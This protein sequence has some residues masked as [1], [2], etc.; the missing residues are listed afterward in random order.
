MA[1]TLDF[2]NNSEGGRIVQVGYNIPYDVYNAAH[3]DLEKTIQATEDALEEILSA[4]HRMRELAV[5]AAND[6]L[7]TQDRSYIQL[8]I[9][10]LKE[11]INRI[12]GT[13]QFNGA[14]PERHGSPIR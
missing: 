5:Q 2:D 7:T 12:A 6:T 1:G 9:D 8:E 11:E 3:T 14:G 4:L 10:Q 13:M